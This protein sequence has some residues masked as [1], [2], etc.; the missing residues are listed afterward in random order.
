MDPWIHDDTWICFP[1][2][3]RVGG[4]SK[5]DFITPSS[6]LPLP[7]PPSLARSYDSSS[8]RHRPPKHPVSN[9]GGNDGNDGYTPEPRKNTMFSIYWLFN[10][11]P[12]RMVYHNSH[13]TG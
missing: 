10:R 11:D 2:S 8:R 7:L 5:V 4:R 12:K 9:N 6:C 3:G 13:I 1:E